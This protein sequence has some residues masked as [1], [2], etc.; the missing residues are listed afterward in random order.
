MQPCHTLPRDDEPGAGGHA[1]EAGS[2]LD[3]VEEQRVA[4]T[5]D[6]QPLSLPRQAGRVQIRW[7][8]KHAPSWLYSLSETQNG[9]IGEPTAAARDIRAVPS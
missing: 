6:K 8:Y 3:P 4:C 5:T 1:Q 2:L 7:V 9:M